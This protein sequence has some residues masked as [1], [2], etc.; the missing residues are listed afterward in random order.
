[1]VQPN[2]LSKEGLEKLKAELEQL[3]T[4][5]RHEVAERIQQSRERGGTVSNAEY[6][7]AKNELAFTEGRILTL[8]NMINNAIIID[9][10][11][12]ERDTVEVGA[13][14]TV[15]NQD[16]KTTQYT[17]TGSAEADPAQG[18]ISNASPIGKSL[19]GKKV[20]EVTEVNAPSGKIKL[21]IV[22]IQ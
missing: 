5:G 3:R 18:K 21:E 10:A 14:V 11:K 4:V 7:E 1:M 2:Y 13:T 9:D 15:K 12:G 20:G 6:E 16:A 19:L 22:S 17:I 8:E